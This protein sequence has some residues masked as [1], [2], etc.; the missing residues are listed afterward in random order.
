MLWNTTLEVKTRVAIG[1]G[2]RQ[3]L[4]S[5]LA[6]INSGKR[7]LVVCQ[8]STAVHW[9]RDLLGS[10]P[11]EEYQVTTLEVPDGESCKSTEWLLRVWEHLQERHFDRKDTIVAL[12]GGS[13]TDLAGF[14]ASTYLRGLNLVLVPTSLLG[15]VDAAI[16]GKTGINLSAGKNL[17]GTFFFPRAVIADQ[18]ILA[19]LPAREFASG[20]GEIIKYA[21]IEE[22]VSKHCDYELG[23]KRLLDVLDTCLTDG[24]FEHDDPGLAGVISSCIKMKLFVVSKDPH[25]TG[26]RRILNLGHTVAHA[27]EKI[28]DFRITH[29]EAV[30]IGLYYDTKL[31]VKQKRIEKTE[32]DRLEEI[33]AKAGLSTNLPTGVTKEKLVSSMM[34][35]KKRE[36]EKI[37]LILPQGKLGCV[38]FEILMPL[39]ELSKTL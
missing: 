12:G 11:G 33:V 34:H 4:A 19:T 30:G 37:K 24:P 21:L 35:D 3:K 15:Q 25:E 31:S 16:G 1:A 39:S 7:V 38:D 2:A 18:E 22:T 36:G 20:L 6:Q 29:G 28:T 26:L 9:L 32:L 10:L 14:A 23:P 27:I 13:V 8:P 5:I 17:A